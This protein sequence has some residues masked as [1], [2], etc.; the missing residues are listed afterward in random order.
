M[1]NVTISLTE[2]LLKQ[3]QEYARRQHTSVNGLIKDLLNQTVGRKDFPR[4]FLALADE[5]KASSKGKKW[6]RESL[7]ER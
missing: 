6:D 4:D 5:V 1:R 3:T 2:T 7:Y